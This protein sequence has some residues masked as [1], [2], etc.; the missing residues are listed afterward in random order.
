M[1]VLLARIHLAEVIKKENIEKLVVGLPLQLDGVEGKRAASTR[2]FIDDFL[3]EF[4]PIE[5]VYQDERYTTIEA[6]DRLL[7][8]GYKTQK[9]EQMI[10]AMSAVIILE[11]YL[12]K[13]Q[14]NGR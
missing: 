2:R 12:R 11:D 4:G 5:V 7:A 9:I 14:N 10:D 13:E 3:K 1:T 6:K 8:M